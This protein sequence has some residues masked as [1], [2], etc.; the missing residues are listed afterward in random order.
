MA[1]GLNGN[2]TIDD[3]LQH[4]RLEEDMDFFQ[5]QNEENKILKQIC[6]H[7]LVTGHKDEIDCKMI[8]YHLDFVSS[9]DRPFWPSR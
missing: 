3:L 7:I 6:T 4:H 9:K 5:F 2:V 8:S 1:T